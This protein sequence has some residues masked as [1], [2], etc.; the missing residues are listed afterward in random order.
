[1]EIKVTKCEAIR[2]GDKIYLAILTPNI[3]DVEKLVETVNNSKK[4]YIADI[5]QEVKKRST[6]ANAYAW[7]LIQEIVNY[8]NL[9]GATETKESIYFQMLRNYGQGLVLT[10][11]TERQI[12][13]AKQMYKYYDE[14][15]EPFSDKPILK[16][17][18]GSSLYDTTEMTILLNGIIHECQQLGIETATP[19]E[20]LKMLNLM[21]GRGN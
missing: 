14:A 10:G 4:P 13:H 17:Y 7:A 21:E 2:W 20:V 1:M 18:I 19:D 3:K 5:K 15:T 16:V 8:L 6:K 9:R 11:L 12:S